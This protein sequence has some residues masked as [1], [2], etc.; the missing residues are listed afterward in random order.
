MSLNIKNPE[1]YR[2]VKELAERTGTS[3]TAAVTQAVREQLERIRGE[4]DGPQ[5]DAERGLAMLAEMRGRFA[6]GYLD[7]DHDALLYDEGG[8]PG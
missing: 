4:T 2:L 7:Q 3:M 6:P 5:L 8:L 1:T